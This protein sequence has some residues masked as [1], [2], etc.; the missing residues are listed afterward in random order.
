MQHIITVK[1]VLRFI[2]Q[3]VLRVIISLID[4]VVVSVVLLLSEASIVWPFL[5]LTLQ[6]YGICARLI[7]NNP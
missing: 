6:R 3:F 5:L 1:R 2:V 7:Q 4:L